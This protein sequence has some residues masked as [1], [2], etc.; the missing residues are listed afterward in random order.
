MRKT[1]LLVTTAA[2]VLAFAAPASAKLPADSIV[3]GSNVYSIGYLNSSITNIEKVNDEIMNNLGTIYYVDK[4]EKAKDIFTASTV[5]DSEIAGKVGNTLTYYAADGTIKKIVTDAYNQYTEPTNENSGVYAIA[6]VTYRQLSPGLYM[7]TFKVTGLSGV[8]SNAAYFKAANS[9]ITS[10]TDTATYI[11]SLAQ[12]DFLYIYGTDGMKGKEI[13]QGQIR[14]TG[15]GDSTYGE[16]NLTISLQPTGN[17]NPIDGSMKGNT[18]YNIANNGLAA[19]D[20]DNKW[21]YYV[22]TADKNKLYKKSINGIEDYVISEDDVKYINVLGDWVYYSNYTDGGKIYKVRTDGTQRQKVTDDMASYINVVGD[23][24]YYINHSDRARIYVLD[25]QGKRLLVGD[26]AKALN[27]TGNFLFYINSSDS[28]KLYSYDFTRNNKEKISDINTQFLNAVSDYLIYYTGQDG[29]LYISRNSPGQAPAVMDVISNIVLKASTVK[30]ISDKASIIAIENENNLY[31]KS[32]EDGGKIYK[33]DPDGNGYKAVDDSADFI[34]LVGDYIYYMKSGKMYVVSKGGDGTEKGVAIAKPKLPDKVVKVEDIPQFSTSSLDKFSFPERVSCMMSDGTIRE[35][36]VNWDKENPKSQKGLYTYT[37]T[38]LGYGTKV[39]MT[40]ALDSGSVN[41]DKVKVKNEAGAKDTVAISGLEKG[42]IV[43]IY[44]E[45][46]PTKALKSATADASGNIN[47]TGLNLNPNGGTIYITVTKSGKAEGGK[48]PC[49]YAP[50]A[51]VGFSIDVNNQKITGLKPDKLY[52]V[53]MD[54]ENANGTLPPLGTP[55]V[56]TTADVNGTI[57][58]PNMKSKIMANKDKKQIVRIVASAA[59]ESAPSLPVQ[60]SKAIVPDYVGL[61]LNLGRIVGTNTGMEYTYDDP[62]SSSATWYTCSSGTTPISLTK[63]LQVAVRVVGGGTVLQ[64]DYKAFGVF[65]MPVVTGIEEGKTYTKDA[66]P[67]VVW[68]GNDS[69]SGITY[70]VKLERNV[71][72]VFEDDFNGDG[73][74]DGKDLTDAI[75]Y[76]ANSDPNNINAA[77]GKYTLT[78]TGTKTNNAMTPSTASNSTVIN[79]MINSSKPSQAEISILEKKGTYEHNQ[80]DTYYKAT[81]TWSDLAGTYSTSTIKMIKDEEGNDIS[82]VTPEV[83]FIRGTSVSQPGVYELKVTTTNRENG[84]VSKAS[85]TFKVDRTEVTL[86]AITGVYEG[87]LYQYIIPTVTDRDQY[88]ITTTALMRDGYT[89]DYDP[90]N[91]PKITINGHYVLILN[92]VNI[93]NGNTQETRISFT[94][95]NT[96]SNIKAPEGITF[97]FGDNKLVGVRAGMEYSLNGG[98]SWTTVTSSDQVLTST[99][100]ETLNNDSNNRI[101]VRY[102][103]TQT[104]QAS[105]PAIIT[106]TKGTKP[107]VGDG[108]VSFDFDNSNQGSLTGVDSTME[109]NLGNGWIDITGTSETINYSDIL[110]QYGIKVRTKATGTTKAS[111]AASISVIQAPAP[112]IKATGFDTSNNVTISGTTSNMEY[113]VDGGTTWHDTDNNTTTI[114]L[115]VTQS[116]TQETLDADKDILVRVKA[117]GTSMP[118]HT[119]KIDVQKVTTTFTIDTPNNKLLGVDSSM[120]YSIDGGITWTNVTGTSIDITNVTSLKLRKITDTMVIPATEINLTTG[121]PLN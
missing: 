54:D 18:S 7:F 29:K 12:T 38:V 64:S 32:Y 27:V 74:I 66:F 37:G 109:Y 26:S 116:G 99:E 87:G 111:D 95:D 73:K 63:S 96:A 4:S 60:V 2:I 22:N 75:I 93:L 83:A 107:Q 28:N 106:L 24:I 117:S 78:V 59:A 43:N 69:T 68:P 36:V 50:E 48:T 16:K 9:T 56:T 30:T 34:N 113:S 6:N 58:V 92:T 84:A 100:V 42:D 76:L 70:T 86:P 98:I 15:I 25:T 45:A 115:G 101:M 82:A 5:N 11:G 8:A 80:Y 61:D 110:P 97:S 35:L 81:P 10:L 105:D 41:I 79:F 120:Q 118:G 112:S 119:A 44:D 108:Y 91:N 14:L 49:V 67:T 103:K 77:D 85:R 20:A 33:L 31:Y 102:A 23:K 55:V 72:L 53:Y 51:P 88:C 17:Y 1:R 89:T 19:I 62:K 71:A 21:I 46:N 104:E 65:P 52:R 3:V 47:I 114:L 39:T 121:K 90:V 13:A 94:I 57:S 40:V